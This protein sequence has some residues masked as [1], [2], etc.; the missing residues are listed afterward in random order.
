MVH[1]HVYSNIS[2]FEL[3]QQKGYTIKTCRTNTLCHENMPNMFFSYLCYAKHRYTPWQT[4]CFYIYMHTY[5]FIVTYECF[6]C[7]KL[8]TAPYSTMGLGCS[9]NILW[10]EGCAPRKFKLFPNLF[11]CFSTISNCTSTD[12]FALWGLFTN[13][14][15]MALDTAHNP[16]SS[17]LL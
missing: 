3:A 14:S 8:L 12:I 17:S 7:K 4:T 9:K 6:M 10:I 1:K 13:A 16:K 11:L 15:I 5:V 2:L